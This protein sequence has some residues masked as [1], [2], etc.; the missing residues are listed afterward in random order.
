MTVAVTRSRVTVT[1]HIVSPTTCKISQLIRA[2]D[3]PSIVQ[4]HRADISMR[5]RL[6]RGLANRGD[7]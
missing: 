5:Q 4:I 1:R 2:Q 6:D 3:K 7:E